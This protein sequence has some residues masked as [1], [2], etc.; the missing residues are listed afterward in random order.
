M[1]KCL[2]LLFMLT[3]LMA[4]FAP[5]NVLATDSKKA[6]QSETQVSDPTAAYDQQ[7][8]CDSLLGSTSDED[9]V[10]WLI[11]KVLNY[12]QILGPLLVVILSSIDFAKVII[13]SDDDAMAKATKKL[14]T[15][16]ILAA[17]LFFL[18]VIV[19]VLLNTFGI[20]TNAVC[21]LK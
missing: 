17:S 3:T 20:T 15:R 21:G 18:P 11:Q 19:S 2:I 16:L 5:V 1:K 13:M 7:Q 9:S 10:A 12:I 8:S 6:T 14:T 4:F